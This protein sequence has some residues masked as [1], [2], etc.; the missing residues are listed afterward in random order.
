MAAVTRRR[1]ASKRASALAG[2]TAASVPAQTLPLS[3]EPAPREAFTTD[4]KLPPGPSTHKGNASLCSFP[5]RVGWSGPSH[6][7]SRWAGGGMQSAPSAGLPDTAR[8]V[9]PGIRVRP[10]I[11]SDNDLFTFCT[12]I[13]IP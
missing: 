3:Q 2:P 10:S 5:P 7:G 13:S 9:M 11:F 8:L 1:S 12:A 4:W 6:N